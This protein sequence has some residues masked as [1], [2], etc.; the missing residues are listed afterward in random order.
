MRISLLVLI[1]VFV[2]ALSSCKTQKMVINYLED[3]KDTTTKKSYYITEP[4]IQK[5]DLLS[6][7][8]SSSSLD[9][10]IDQLYNLQLTPGASQG[11]SQMLGYLVDQK[12]YVELPR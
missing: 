6:V 3:L 8:V 12:G 11:N 5:N 10:Q 9:P 7:Q 1:S 2:L 4:V